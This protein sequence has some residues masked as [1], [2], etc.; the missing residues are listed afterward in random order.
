MVISYKFSEFNYVFKYL[1]FNWSPLRVDAIPHHFYENGMVPVP[2]LHDELVV[3]ANH[4]MKHIRIGLP[5]SHLELLNKLK[6]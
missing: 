5:C 6:V 2:A 4:K 3:A 1:M